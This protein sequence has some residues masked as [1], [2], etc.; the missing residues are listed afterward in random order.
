MSQSS[1]PRFT[2]FARKP[3]V[4]V[5]QIQRV[6]EEENRELRNGRG[7]PIPCAQLIEI[8]EGQPKPWVSKSVGG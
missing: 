2:E 5:W 6:N 7:A 8:I 3:S 4:Q 1:I